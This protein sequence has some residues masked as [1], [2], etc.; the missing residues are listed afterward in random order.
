MLPLLPKGRPHAWT[1]RADA[2]HV[3]LPVAGAER[4]QDHP[5]RAIRRMTD[6]VFVSLSPR[7]TKMYSEIGRPSIPP[8][9]F[10]Q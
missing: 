4:R 1:R 3:Q 2:P 7:F 10:A 6:E 9:L 8:E 5:L